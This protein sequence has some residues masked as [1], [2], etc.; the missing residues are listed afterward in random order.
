MIST[1]SL[2]SVKHSC[3]KVV[4]ATEFF[5]NLYFLRHYKYTDFA[6]FIMIIGMGNKIPFWQFQEITVTIIII[7]K[8]DILI[9][10]FFLTLLQLSPQYP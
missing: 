6:L 9:S 7:L 10:A 3:K 4:E 2:K 1:I 8:L 5:C